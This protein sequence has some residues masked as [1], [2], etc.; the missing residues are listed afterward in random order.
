[1]GSCSA[2]VVA[3]EARK[4]AATAPG[5][6]GEAAWPALPAPRRSRAA[7]VTLSRRQ[8]ALPPTSAQRRRLTIFY[9]LI[10]IVWWVNHELQHHRVE[11]IP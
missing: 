4:H 3:V 5:G 10:E 7:V 6:D 8:A 11:I 9:S 1:V 2:D